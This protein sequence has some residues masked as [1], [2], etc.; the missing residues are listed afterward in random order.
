ML[1]SM[2]IKLFN[3]TVLP[4]L[5][6]GCEVWGLGKASPLDVLH[7][8]FLKSLLKVK[9]TT[10]NCFVYGELGVFPL[11]IE[12][13]VRIIK[14]WLKIIS[15]G[16]VGDNFTGIVYRELFNL[17]LLQPNFVT[18]CTKIR[19]LLNMT[20]FGNVWLDQYVQDEREFVYIFRQ[21]V[22]DMY[23]QEWSANI[24]L[25]SKNRIFPN[26]KTRFCFEPYLDM[27]NSCL[28][29]A[30]SRIRLSSH[31]FLIE[32]GRWGKKR[33][34]IEM[35][36]CTVCNVLEDEFHVL[37]ECPKYKNQ[38]RNCLPDNLKVKPSMFSFI[39]YIKS[40]DMVVQKQLALLC[41]RIQKEYRK[42][43]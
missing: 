37:I 36:K 28:R 7:L 31:M 13:Q 32:R 17:S 10:P 30:V 27:N 41:Y 3:T 2:Q 42:N 1:P 23:L 29:V 6:Y 40:E 38:R 24:S 35:R 8:S 25:T 14:F 9:T 20:G 5:T 19:D 15:V 43:I 33:I 11:S 16:M 18:W 22:T 26:I 4:I 39:N 12:R 21:R 34:D